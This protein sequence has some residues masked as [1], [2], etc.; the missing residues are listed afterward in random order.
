MLYYFWPLDLVPWFLGHTAL[1]LVAKKYKKSAV[2]N[3]E[4]WKIFDK[5]TQRSRRTEN[6]NFANVCQ[7]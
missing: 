6:A 5:S 3:M 7:H 1:Y 2:E 4:C